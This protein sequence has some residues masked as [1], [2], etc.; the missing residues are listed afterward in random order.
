MW[1]ISSTL[2][3]DI[4]IKLVHLIRNKFVAQ[5]LTSKLLAT[6]FVSLCWIKSRFIL[7]QACCASTSTNLFYCFV[8]KTSFLL[9]KEG[10]QKI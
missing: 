7:L 4:F 8:I 5:Q 9:A 10:L 2:A 6:Y 1:T 3:T